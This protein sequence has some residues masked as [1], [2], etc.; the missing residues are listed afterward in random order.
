M[1]DLKTANAFRRFRLRIAEQKEIIREEE[2]LQTFWC[3]AFIVTVVLLVISFVFM[4]HFYGELRIAQ[5]DSNWKPLAVGATNVAD[6]TDTTPPSTGDVIY[7]FEDSDDEEIIAHGNCVD[8]ALNIITILE[9]DLKIENA[10]VAVSGSTVTGFHVQAMI[11]DG[12]EKTYLKLNDYFN[13]VPSDSEFP[14]TTIG[15]EYLYVP[16][17][18]FREAAMRFIPKFYYTDMREFLYEKQLLTKGDHQ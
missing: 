7:Y 14:L 17:G 11:I 3:I 15:E 1:A 2:R 10:F 16:A 4:L 8:K 9:R 18:L 5:I 13:V 12:E 6:D